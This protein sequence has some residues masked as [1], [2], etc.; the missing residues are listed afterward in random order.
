[1]KVSV[2]ERS[3]TPTNLNTQY[4]KLPSHLFFL[5]STFHLVQH[6]HIAK[7]QYLILS[8]FRSA[9]LRVTMMATYLIIDHDLSLSVP[10]SPMVHFEIHFKIAA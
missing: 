6:F 2:N 8:P 5:C 4:N 10:H 7:L 3:I 1:L 9:P